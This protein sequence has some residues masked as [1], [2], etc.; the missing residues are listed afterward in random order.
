MNEALEVI[1]M[2]FVSGNEPSEVV[3]PCKES[4]CFPAA[5]IASTRSESPGRRSQE[6]RS[7]SRFF[8][9]STEP[10]RSQFKIRHEERSVPFKAF[11]EP[12]RVPRATSSRTSG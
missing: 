7:F 5:D 2:S 12:C 8:Y 6:K 4:L 11:E 3:H 1:G 10:L 9:Q